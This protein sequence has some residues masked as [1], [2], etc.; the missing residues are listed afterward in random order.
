MT[1]KPARRLR[2]RGMVRHSRRPE[3]NRHPYRALH[4]LRYL[5]RGTSLRQS[6]HRH[7]PDGQRPGAV[8]PH[9]CGPGQEDTGGIRR[10]GNAIEFP[11]H[12]VQ[13]S[14]KRPTAALDR[15]LQYLSLV[16]VLFGYPLGGVVLTTGC[17]KTTP[18]PADGCCYRRYSSNCPVRRP[19]AERL[20]ARQACRFRDHSM[21]SP[22]L[23]AEGEIDDEEFVQ[24]VA[25]LPPRPALQHDGTATTMNRCR[26]TRMSLP[27]VRGFRDRTKNGPRWPTVPAG[28]LW[29]W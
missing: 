17:D 3:R 14:G 1:D 10:R 19:H 26:G 7:S 24:L 23:L 29:P 20:L 2:T 15:N 22:Q 27:A 5:G 28:E 21:G 9:P 12:P 18:G 13:E 25:E 4:Q 6:D 11:V 16:E 8:Q